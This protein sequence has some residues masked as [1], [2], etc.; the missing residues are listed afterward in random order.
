P[1]FDATTPFIDSLIS[2]EGVRVITLHMPAGLDDAAILAEQQELLREFFTR[3][4]ELKEYIAWFYTPLA[5]DLS[6]SLPP[7]ALTVYDC[8]DELSAFKNAPAAISEK[9]SVLMSTADLVFTGGHSLYEA[10]RHLHEHIFPFPSSIDK[11]HFGKARYDL[12]TPADQQSIPHPR[13]GFFG[14]IDE[15]FDI[16]MVRDAAR[17][18]PEWHFIIIGPIVKIDPTTLPTL[19]N[20]HYLGGKSYDELPAYLGSWDIAMIPFAMNES[21]RFISPTKTPEYLAG[22]IPVVS[23]PIRDVV[24]PYGEM[25]LVQIA[26]SPN[27]FITGVDKALQNRKDAGWLTRVDNYL[28]GLSWDITWKQMQTLITARLENKALTNNLNDEVYV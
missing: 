17:L 1:V 13:I 25:D 10:K 27:E 24:R 7:A 15:R 26:S 18:K 22:G 4:F 16:V 5:I 21:T 8:M 23:T 6:D 12:I 3:S 11:S 20:I 28:A 9:E 19:P 14:V 2:K